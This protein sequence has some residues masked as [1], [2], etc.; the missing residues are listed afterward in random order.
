MNINEADENDDSLPYMDL[1]P[2]EHKIRKNGKI[3]LNEL[4]VIHLCTIVEQRHPEKAANAR[5]LRLSVSAHCQKL[6]AGG[7]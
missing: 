6:R 5:R 3:L 7:E 4:G 2:E 1:I